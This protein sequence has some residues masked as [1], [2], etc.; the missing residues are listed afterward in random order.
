MTIANVE[1]RRQTHHS[2][3]NIAGPERLVSV[4]IGARLLIDSARRDF[5]DGLFSSILGA[6][7]VYRGLSGHCP[8][9]AF[10]GIDNRMNSRRAAATI[11][12]RR[13]VRV[14]KVITVNKP[15]EHLYQFW[16][17]PENFPR[18]MT[19]VAA[20]RRD[21][22]TKS[23]WEMKS[24]GGLTYEWDAEIFNEKAN[25]LIAWRSLSGADI[26]HAG[27]VRFEPLKRN[28]GTMV[29]L[30]MEYRPPLTKISAVIAKLFG[31]EPGQVITE[32]L[33]RF[34]QLMEAGEIAS[35]EGQARGLG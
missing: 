21:T 5:R 19:H 12:H 6:G 3:Q 13:G 24:L 7:L 33:R 18:F 32:D 17:N 10:A 22:D 4:I 8:I 11:P 31:E 2:M 28:R 30:M 25:E 1:I 9:Y 35:V 34:K 29:K 27:S 26:D 15:V 23:H 14:E 16:R 20:V